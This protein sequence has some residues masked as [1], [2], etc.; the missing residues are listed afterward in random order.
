M[1]SPIHLTDEH[2]SLSKTAGSHLLIRLADNS[3]SYAIVDAEHSRPLVLVKNKLS[4]QTES[5]SST[6]KLEIIL[7][8]NP[9]LKGDFGKVKI[10][11]E[12]KAFTFIPAELYDDADL[13]Q[14]SKFVG[15]TC[16]SEVLS[17][18]I[19]AYGIKT[20][21]AIDAALVTQL[22]SSFHDP[23]IVSQANP[24]LNGVYQLVVSG[25]PEGLF[26]HFNTGSFEAAIV[27]NGILEFYNIFEIAT[28]DEFNYFLLNLMSQLTLDQN[29]AVSLSGEIN[30]EDENFERV[31]KYFDKID[32]TGS[33]EMNAAP[34]AFSR[35][36]A[37]TFLALLSLGLCE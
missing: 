13:P 19:P 2:F 17:S 29:T 31:A 35:V 20:V 4:P 10:S 9:Y 16:E 23:L 24:F 15:S 3:Y 12:T 32:F 36:P 11:V 27:R 33:Q 28:A 14:Y 30:K 25:S 6:E 21:C 7:T 26:L 18:D 1:N 34:E 5:M 37:H 22:K 8:E